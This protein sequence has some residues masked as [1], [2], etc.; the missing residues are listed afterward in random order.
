VPKSV[1]ACLLVL[2]PL[3]GGAAPSFSKISV[4]GQVVDAVG[5]PQPEATGADDQILI[6]VR[7]NAGRTTLRSLLVLRP[8][9]GRIVA[10][11]PPPPNDAVFFDACPREK[12][13]AG[14]VVYAGPR[15]LMDEQ[16]THLLKKQSLFVLPDPRGLKA[17]PL[18]AKMGTARGELRLLGPDGLWVLSPGATEAYLLPLNIRARAYSDHLKNGVGPGKPYENAL[19]VYIPHFVDVDFDGDGRTDLMTVHE[20]DVHLF[21]RQ[22]DGT[23]KSGGDLDLPALLSVQDDANIRVLV[24]NLDGKGAPELVVSESQGLLPKKTRVFQVSIAPTDFSQV[25]V[26]RLWQ[27]EGL[28]HPLGVVSKKGA[29]DLLVYTLPTGTLS[30]VKGMVTGEVPLE[31]SQWRAD[32]KRMSR[33]Y[34]VETRADLWRGRVDGALPVQGIDFDGDGYTDLLDLGQGHRARIFP[35]GKDGFSPKSRNAFKVPGF[36]LVRAL[37]EVGAALLWRQGRGRHKTRV[38]VIASGARAMNPG[39][40]QNPSPDATG[41]ATG[42]GARRGRL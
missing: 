39:A 13:G 41:D 5:L 25:K 35:G 12:E 9:E 23:L 2:S 8:G 36:D 38:W 7:K 21:L 3:L 4:D 28:V 42:Q 17:A 6:S 34:Q 15:G 33:L 24:A 26:E 1:L 19:S 16:G 29:D 32:Q 37:P 10:T 22:D 11:L 40:R 14:E 31:F 27:R 18:C 30:F 20:G